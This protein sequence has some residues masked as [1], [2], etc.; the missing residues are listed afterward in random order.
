M[1]AARFFTNFQ[2]NP[3][4]LGPVEPAGSALDWFPLVIRWWRLSKQFLD[5]LSHTSEV[6]NETPNRLDRR[7]VINFVK[8]TSRTNGVKALQNFQL[9][10]WN[11]YP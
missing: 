2:F 9:N 5:E 8:V 11:T 10:N 6:T 1:E 4:S 7:H 3:A